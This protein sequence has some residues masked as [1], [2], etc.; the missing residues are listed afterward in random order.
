MKQNMNKIFKSSSLIAFVLVM[1]LALSS[2]SLILGNSYDYDFDYDDDY[3][4]DYYGN[5]TYVKYTYDDKADTF[6]DGETV[7]QRVELPD[8]FSVDCRSAARIM[9]QTNKFYAAYKSLSCNGLIYIENSD[10]YV[11]ANEEGMQYLRKLFNGDSDIFRLLDFFNYTAAMGDPVGFRSIINTENKEPVEISF[12]TI[13]NSASYTI[14]MYDGSDVV[15]AVL[16]T[17]YRT[18]IFDEMYYVPIDSQENIGYRLNNSEMS[19]IQNAINKLSHDRHNEEYQVPSEIKEI[20]ST[21]WDVLFGVLYGILGVILPVAGI[22]FCVVD[23]SGGK[24]GK[25][26]HK[27]RNIVLMSLLILWIAV[28]FA[29]LMMLLI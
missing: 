21:V 24:K 29:I 10:R 27:A 16:G 14:A 20:S 15:E 26:V 18:D 19:A 3:Y 2:C 25:E 9:N 17:V 5:K 22:I 6:S 8:N 7:Y 1:I 23:L 28:A 13:S 4:D 12:Y 11:Y